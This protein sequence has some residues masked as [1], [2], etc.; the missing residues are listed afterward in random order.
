MTARLSEMLYPT[1][2]KQVWLISHKKRCDGSKIN[3]FLIAPHNTVEV[4]FIN[5]HV[6]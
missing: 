1:T 6:V 3:L 4:D 2:P 5:I